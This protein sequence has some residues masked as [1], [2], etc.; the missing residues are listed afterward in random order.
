MMIS[1]TEMVMILLEK[2]DKNLDK[3]SLNEML[4]YLINAVFTANLLT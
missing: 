4:D 3:M 2:D 1:I